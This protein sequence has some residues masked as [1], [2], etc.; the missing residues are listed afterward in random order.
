MH[1]HALQYAERLAVGGGVVDV[2]ALSALLRTEAQ[3]MD[4]LHAVGLEPEQIGQLVRLDTG[5]KSSGYGVDIRDSSV[6]WL[7]DL[8]KDR[9]Y[10]HWAKSMQ[11]ILRP[12]YPGMTRSIARN[13]FNLVFMVE[14]AK[15]EAQVLL[16]TAESFFVNDIPVRIGKI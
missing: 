9:K 8:E 6:Q 14:P 1:R 13:F 10:N 4:G 15:A 3:L 11:E 12:T 5:V 2:F 16:K 7:N